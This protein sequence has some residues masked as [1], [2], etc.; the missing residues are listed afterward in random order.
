MDDEVKDLTTIL[1]DPHRDVEGN[2]ASAA[3]LLSEHPLDIR[4][5]NALYS[6]CSYPDLYAIEDGLLPIAGESI[7][8]IISDRDLM[9]DPLKHHKMNPKYFNEFHHDALETALRQLTKEQ[10]EEVTFYTIEN[11]LCS[12]AM[13]RYFY[14]I[15]SHEAFAQERLDPLRAS[16]SAIGAVKLF[17]RFKQE[18]KNYYLYFKDVVMHIIGQ[19]PPV[20]IYPLLIS[21]VK[22]YRS[23]TPPQTEFEKYSHFHI[24][25]I[26]KLACGDLSHIQS[27]LSRLKEW[28]VKN[29]PEDEL[30]MKVMEL[31]VRADYPQAYEVLKSIRRR[32]A[33]HEEKEDN[34]KEFHHA[35]YIAVHW[36]IKIHLSP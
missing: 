32:Q 9:K 21:L 3:V 28:I 24:V 1:L 33:A 7:G 16:Q 35:W 15:V 13:S 10:F 29:L 14:K 20:A 4:A 19:E 11:P 8:K 2:R 36:I 26:T 5:F 17:K 34:L 18:E 31:I 27:L 6:I 25:L 30:Y 23:F 22:Y 12:E